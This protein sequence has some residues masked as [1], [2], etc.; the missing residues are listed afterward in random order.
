[1]D[2]CYI[3]YMKVIFVTIVVNLLLTE[4]CHHISQTY[5]NVN[6]KSSGS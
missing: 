1:M 3:S 6:E 2:R 5:L 4:A